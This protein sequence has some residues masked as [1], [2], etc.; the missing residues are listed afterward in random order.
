MKSSLFSTTTESLNKCFVYF[1]Q[2]VFNH[3][4]M[5]LCRL[6]CKMGWRL[7]LKVKWKNQHIKLQ[8]H[9][10]FQILVAMCRWVIMSILLLFLKFLLMK[11]Y[12]YYSN[13]FLLNQNKELP[14]KNGKQFLDVKFPALF[15]ERF[16]ICHK[17]FSKF[18]V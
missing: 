5:Q 6:D 14:F 7:L 12:F 15:R 17:T 4:I 3:W 11:F 9:S 1:L 8:A 13:K 10:V 2:T 18:V 16:N